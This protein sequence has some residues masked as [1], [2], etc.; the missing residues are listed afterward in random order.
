MAE[1]EKTLTVTIKI[2]ES[3]YK[4]IEAAGGPFYRNAQG[5]GAVILLTALGLWRGEKS[6]LVT[7]PNMLTSVAANGTSVEG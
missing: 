2:P 4:K 3:T 6:P 7:S 5:Q 1:K